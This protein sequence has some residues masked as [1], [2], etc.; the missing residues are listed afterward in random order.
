MHG[1]STARCGTELRVAALR[2]AE[3][4]LTTR[5]SLCP[6]TR[7]RRWFLAKSPAGGIPFAILQAEGVFGAGRLSLACQ[8]LRGATGCRAQSA[9]IDRAAAGRDV[10]AGHLAGIAFDIQLRGLPAGPEAGGSRATTPDAIDECGTSG[11]RFTG[12][13]LLATVVLMTD[14]TGVLS[15]LR[16]ARGRRGGRARL[17]GRRLRRQE[18][19]QKQRAPTEDNS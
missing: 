7:L 16:A 6:A 12:T 11:V 15:R 14:L 2:L 10:T 8:N 17:G 19:Q 3:F 18:G 4:H 5:L 13:A 1:G 9:R